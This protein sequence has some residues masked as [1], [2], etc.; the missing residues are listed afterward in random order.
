MI[1][2]S[3]HRPVVFN[4]LEVIESFE[5]SIDYRFSLIISKH[6]TETIRKSLSPYIGP[7][8]QVT[9]IRKVLLHKF[10]SSQTPGELC[11]LFKIT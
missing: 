8:A 2:Y 6:K 5:S 11:S 9:W 1:A 3:I 4:L 7:M 10:A